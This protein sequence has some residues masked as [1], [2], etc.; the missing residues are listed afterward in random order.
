MRQHL[1]KLPRPAA[2]A[3]AAP[4]RSRR[5]TAVASFTK[6]DGG[7]PGGRGMESEME[8]VYGCVCVYTRVLHTR[9]H[10]RDTGWSSQPPTP[11]ACDACIS[12]PR[13]AASCSSCFLATSTARCYIY[14]I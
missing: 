11:H 13:D 1:K 8:M 5:N 14:Y 2:G 3:A 10:V 12:T 9:I 4:G 6:I 7:P